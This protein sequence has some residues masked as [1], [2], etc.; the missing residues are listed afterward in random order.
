MILC[1]IKHTRLIRNHHAF[2]ITEMMMAVAFS[3]VLMTGVYSFY[4]AASQS[5]A[6]GIS[7]QT[8]Q[9]AAD[10][11]LNKIIEGKA[12]T[13][14]TSGLPSTVVY[15]LSTSSSFFLYP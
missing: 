5:S 8:L 7:G 15:R 12:E 2:T 3:L 13:L 10:T 4:I 6:Y 1:L 9:D 14:V 11:I